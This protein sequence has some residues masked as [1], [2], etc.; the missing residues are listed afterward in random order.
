MFKITNQFSKKIIAFT[1]SA[2]LIV[3]AS[4]F[5]GQIAR[6]ATAPDL[7]VS[8]GAEIGLPT[9]DVRVVIMRIIRA[10]LGLLG[11]VAVGLILYAGFLWMTAGG[12][13]D[14][15]GTAKKILINS[16]IGLAIILSSY[17]I[18][19]FIMN[20]LV[21][22]TTG[23]SQNQQCIGAECDGGSG[24]LPGG[25]SSFYISA[26]PISGP[27]CIRNVHPVI[28]FSR[29]VDINSVNRESN[30]TLVK[31]NAERVN[32][33]WNYV[34]GKFNVIQFDA[35]SS[36]APDEGNDCLE[37]N[38]TYILNINYSNITARGNS[39]VS[40]IGCRNSQTGVINTENCNG[41]N[42]KTGD[43]V[44]RKAPYIS[45]VAPAAGSSSQI[46]FPVMIRV[47]FDDDNGVQSINLFRDGI[48]ADSKTLTGC[49]KSGTL[50]L[51]WPTAGM[52]AGAYDLE[53]V[54]LDWA[55]GQGKD[56]RRLV[57]LPEHCFDS[58]QNEGETDIDCGGECRACPGSACVQNSE[59][60]SGFCDKGK[61][62]N[63][64]YISDYAPKSGA[65]GTMVAVVG[66]FFGE[67]KG[68]GGVYFSKV[69]NPQRDVEAD[70]IEAPVVD[71]NLGVDNWTNNQVVVR[72][73]VG[74]VSGPIKI[75]R[76]DKIYSDL[77]NDDVGM[78]LLDFQVNNIVRPGICA[79]NPSSALPESD[80]IISGENFGD[81]Q[82]NPNV[83]KTVFGL[84]KAAVKNWSGTSIRAVV[85][86]SDVATVGVSVFN[87]DIESN[88]YRFTVL[89]G[90]SETSPVVSTIS[91]NSGPGGTY[92]TIFGKNF[93]SNPGRVH[94]HESASEASAVISGDFSFPDDC[95]QAVW[96][97]DKVIVKFPKG[98]GTLNTN[99]FVQV[100]TA[101]NKSSEFNNSWRFKL[102]E[103]VL[104]P[105][106]CKITP[107]AG[108]VPFPQ[109]YSPMEIIGENFGNTKD[110][111]DVYFWRAG[112]RNDSIN[113]RVKVDKGNSFVL[114][115]INNGQKI[116]LFPPAGTETGDVVAV[117]SNIL[118][119]P[120]RFEVSDCT[121][122]TPGKPAN[123]CVEAGTKCCVVGSDKGLCRPVGELCAGET[124][125]AGYIWR[126]STGKIP[127]VPHVV[128]RCDG[129]NNI[130]T[131]SPRKEDGSA[132]RDTCRT[133]LAVIEF[134][135]Q[136]DPKTVTK[137]LDN[138]IVNSC[139]DIN[140]GQCVNPIK[141]DLANSS[142][143]LKAAVN[144]LGQ[145]PRDYL[146]LQP[147]AGRWA[148]NAWYQVVLKTGIKSLAKTGEPALSLAQD[149]AC[150]VKDSAYCYV[151][152]TGVE[153]CHL[154]KVII[155]P[156]SYLTE[157]LG[158]PM[159]DKND[160]VVNYYGN[161]LSKQ[162]CVMMNMDG[163]IWDWSV[164]EADRLYTDIFQTRGL[165][166]N[167]SALSNTVAVGLNRPPIDAVNISVT[168][169]KDGEPVKVGYSP[170]TIDLSA[171]Q[172]VDAWPKCLE[173]CTNVEVG[174]KFSTTMSASQRY[175]DGLI[176]PMGKE[177]V[178]LYTC[179][180]EN[181]LSVSANPV[182]IGALL[183]QDKQTITIQYG[184]SLSP[185]TIYKA[186]V[187]AP[188]STPA[189]P[190]LGSA[191]RLNDVAIFGKPMDQ[192][193][194]WV[195]RTKKDSCLI[196]RVEVAPSVFMARDVHD[197]AIFSAQPYSSPD[198]CNA[199]GQK[200]NPWSVGWNW[201]S[202]VES[203]ATVSTSA[204]KGKNKYCT[205]SCVRKG[206]DIPST[207]KVGFPICGNGMVEAG[208]DCDT[209]NK[210]KN[211][212]LNCLYLGN[213]TTCGNGNIDRE[214]NYAVTGYGEE[215]D[216]TV[217]ATAIG[218]DNT[219][220][221]T[222]SKISATP[223]VG[224]SVC[225]NST[226]G[227]GED[228]DLGIAGDLAQPVSA[229]GCSSNCLHTGS[230][231]S[232]AWCNNQKVA[233]TYGGFTL[234]E[235]SK[236]CAVSYSQ[237]GNKVA[238]PDEDSSCDTAAGV[239][240]NCNEFC[241]LKIGDS[242]EDVFN[243]SCANPNNDILSGCN[244][245]F[246][247]KGSSLYYDV[248]SVCGD[249]KVGI[250]EDAGCESQ[251]YF[252]EVNSYYKEGLFDPWVLVIGQGRGAS[253]PNTNPPEQKTDIIG[254]TSQD[255][256]GGVEK[257]GRGEYKI[258]CGFTTDDECKQA[259]GVDY[260]VGADS[261][262]YLYPKVLSTVPATANPIKTNVCPN[263]AIEIN[264]SGVIDPNT[265]SG[266]LVIAQGVDVESCGSLQDVTSLLAINDQQNN[267]W[268]E[269]LASKV[270]K[271][272]KDVFSPDA[273]AANGQ[274]R[275]WCAGKDLGTPTVIVGSD[276][277]TSKVSV[278]LSAPLTLNTQ[279]AVILKPGIKDIRGVSVGVDVKQIRRHLFRYGKNINWQFRTGIKVCAI[280]SVEVNPSQHYFSRAYTGT[281]LEAVAKT[282]SG[283]SIQ[284]IQ[285]SYD[286]NYV[287]GPMQNVYVNLSATN[288]NINFVTSTNVNG[289]I[290]IRASANVIEN[291][292]VG[293][294]GSVGLAATG[295]AH[296]IV[297][298]CENP[299]P[300]KDLFLSDINGGKTGPFNILP[301]EDRVNNN[302]G[303]D[304]L[305]DQFNNTA[306]AKAD[307]GGY[308]NF[309][310]YYCADSG[311]T[312]KND[313][314]P[315][316]R[317]AVQGKADQLGSSNVGAVLLKRF[318]LT[319]NKNSDAIGIQILRN[320]RH[321][322]VK[323]WYENDAAAGGA[324]FVGQKQ[325]I[326]IDGYDAYADS[327]NIYV[328]AL[329]ITN[330]PQANSL[331][332]VYNNIY[333]FSINNDASK[334]TRTVF[335]QVVKNLRFNVN[336]TNYGFCGINE[337]NPNF[338]TQ[339]Q[340]DL[341]CPIG[342][343]CSAQID[344]LKRNY[345]RLR[346]LNYIQNELDN[347]ANKNNGAYPA[348]TEG[349][350]L[351]G[352]AVSTWNMG[353]AALGT[354][355]GKSLPVDP[356][357]VLGKAGTCSAAKNKACTVDGQCPQG[358]TC[359]L[360]DA[361]TG[362][363]DADRRYSFACN[364]NSLAF[365]YSHTPEN[366]GYIL[367]T[368]LEK[369]FG[370][371]NNLAIGN[372]NNFLAAFL[373]NTNKVQVIGENNN[374]I[375]T[376]ADE[377]SSEQAGGCGDG[378]INSANE[379]CDPKGAKEY[380]PTCVNGKVAVKICSEQCKWIEAPSEDCAGVL[381][382][383]GNG[384]K[385]VGE[386]CDEGK[387]LNGKYGH[388]S[389]DCNSLGEACG[390]GRVN[391]PNEL[392]DWD[393][394]RLNRSLFSVYAPPNYIGTCAN[395]GSVCYS[396]NDCPTDKGCSNNANKRCNTV[397]DCDTNFCI[398]NPGR[399]CSSG[400]YTQTKVLVG[401]KMKVVITNP[402]K[403][404]NVVG[405]NATCATCA[406]FGMTGNDLA[407]CYLSYTD[408]TCKLSGEKYVCNLVG[409]GSKFGE[410]NLGATPNCVKGYKQ[411]YNCTVTNKGQND[412]CTYD[413]KASFSL[414]KAPTNTNCAVDNSITCQ[415]SF[416]SCNKLPSPF[417]ISRKNG[418]DLKIID[419]ENKVRYARQAENSCNWDCKTRGPYCGDGVIQERYGEECDGNEI[420]TVGG[421]TGQRVCSNTCNM[422]TPAA[423]NWRFDS[424][425][426]GQDSSDNKLNALDCTGHCPIM[427]NNG[428]FGTAGNFT[429]TNYLEVSH[430]NKLM[431]DKFTIEAWINPQE[432]NQSNSVIIQKSGGTTGGYALYL[433]K[434]QIKF[435]I[436][437][438]TKYANSVETAISGNV[439]GVNNWIH[440]LGVYD[441]NN[442]KLYVNSQQVAMTNNISVGK[443]DLNLMI[444]AGSGGTNG[445]RGKIDE[446]SYYDRVLTPAEISDRYQNAKG[447]FCSTAPATAVKPDSATARCGN[448]VVD[449]SL[450]EQCDL[451]DGNNGV[452][453]TPAYNRTCTYCSNDC[454]TI[455]RDPISFCG[456]G[457]I[458]TI[459]AATGA[460]EACDFTTING[461]LNVWSLTKSGAT[462]VD[463]DDV[464]KGY[465][466]KTCSSDSNPNTYYKGERS[467]ASDCTAFL[468]DCVICGFDDKN[469]VKIVGNL[470]DVL[471]A[472]GGYRGEY[473]NIP[474]DYGT[475][476]IKLFINNSF[477]A[478]EF[479]GGQEGA[480]KQYS[481]EKVSANPA[482]SNS[483]PAYRLHL[484]DNDNGHN[485]EHSLAVSLDPNPWQYDLILSPTIF[486]SNHFQNRPNDIRVV[487]SWTGAGNEA[488][489]VSG[490]FVPS[491]AAV[492][493]Y[494]NAYFC[495][496]P[497]G[498]SS[499]L[500]DGHGKKIGVW[501][502]QYP[503]NDN[504]F[505]HLI[506]YT[507]DTSNKNNAN[508]Y[509]GVDTNFD[510]LPANGTSQWPY[511]ATGTYPFYIKS[512]AGPIQN[513]NTNL[514]VSVYLP[515]V[516]SDS[517]SGYYDKPDQVFDFN[518]VKTSDYEGAEYW[519][520]FNIRR[521]DF[522][523]VGAV[524][525]RI[526]KVKELNIDDNSITVLSDGKIVTDPRDFNYR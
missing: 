216:P 37:A 439:A 3:V 409:V 485:V 385:E 422:V 52:K 376:Q 141:V 367:R 506:T 230:Q 362:W 516:Y 402:K 513:A 144:Q 521:A 324:G 284:P 420:C 375:C 171:P 82:I 240:D 34:N 149:R 295:R 56:D 212:S 334:E 66:R 8:Y 431:T 377:I 359:V 400:C 308:F 193:Y 45:F 115:N 391:E 31:Q 408:G 51:S 501:Y 451:G 383:C 510:C 83:Y 220:R 76:G 219:C 81:A 438:A 331:G 113:G 42:I 289:E 499:K 256:A 372:W 347:Y 285:G 456:D 405:V 28:T 380:D 491:I 416:A 412:I 180:D 69:A 410:I 163:Y 384:K 87:N 415:S 17:S 222:G 223:Q 472:D 270:K 432:I 160:Q 445:F 203:V 21:E 444:G 425:K 107:A 455:S 207:T 482:C 365:R 133:S 325:S 61:C 118:S 443:S 57:L 46:G 474:G 145:D 18:V 257:N 395:T 503:A 298:L 136:I 465:K 241:L 176:S 164:A 44:D 229:L 233:G 469:G 251:Q 386:V 105:G 55:A 413:Y 477:V 450:N 327:N 424:N 226:I 224:L 361:A 78:S 354:A 248:P 211:C 468:P 263:T 392:C 167:V 291:K 186:V 208:E 366:S 243:N 60:A 494:D 290:D 199:N 338:D 33:T 185:N 271:I 463:F 116:N 85:P 371:D 91:P 345:S 19:S 407:N 104:K 250:G 459:N 497:S 505:T 484:T 381:T 54:A 138:V 108:P 316:F 135:K 350:F 26:L 417:F 511:M 332:N 132:R 162:T 84:N 209:P 151:F 237:C 234:E 286:W 399:L 495:G 281:I 225:N 4:L 517:A 210:E 32:G 323:E 358:E 320:D 487:V 294:G 169:N 312:G 504:L 194:S 351:P 464:R 449:P 188:S 53:A 277:T 99:Y 305:S 303:Y 6:A 156:Y 15:V 38:T 183:S 336:L 29:E 249:A 153:D 98:L 140:N 119:N 337:A 72:V 59:C 88:S 14:Q 122:A 24:G 13:E 315:Y 525:N 246:N 269:F 260:S 73:P 80:V 507:I 112:A 411:S 129:G 296:L 317:V 282:E 103:G 382:T 481:V 49:Q 498:Y 242:P 262:C 67:D 9:T 218:C 292:S 486:S 155:T 446:V 441:G 293:A 318:I 86:F 520:V 300:P 339:C 11:I 68:Q 184:A 206:S 16:V 272:F 265:L 475:K 275:K 227:S 48:L 7:G 426:I 97:N 187:S 166:A 205:S 158:E 423:A 47:K 341:D 221:R 524:E 526:S 346:S 493:M 388:C 418:E 370:S 94:F 344:K 71:C 161:G 440:V 179:A 401:A 189:I 480:K 421:V 419:I 168:A 5:V 22:A 204:S 143:S 306:M 200:L 139:S 102:V 254:S 255:T 142:F 202:S 355:V 273:L 114:S 101:D 430:N 192:E 434:T 65:I 299:W 373:K 508:S 109:G 352:Q 172:V 280:S 268:Y 39:S 261:C 195:F 131:P 466:V 313:D 502:H 454:R 523:G 297:F 488:S 349:T 274:P 117:V 12:N 357:D 92:I 110:N 453:C 266:N 130:P 512:V 30:I 43:G 177:A 458:D 121:I 258:A 335:E 442:G 70:W 174:V 253:D 462:E 393:E 353:W 126:F 396:D 175:A 288:S 461:L 111:L 433:D 120:I 64:M 50:D 374:G 127:A 406:D 173:A 178:R 302:D 191:A 23:Q 476:N 154:D 379:E 181:C 515:K 159:K 490:F 368:K 514:K 478:G 460:K 90:I 278:K 235:F 75:V 378:I 63:R 245:A 252:T 360:H 500:E 522:P 457:V 369:I 244:E 314:L 231:L 182:N 470:L 447:W 321:L 436:Y 123:S 150:E 106:I 124:L 301:F 214:Q 40:L 333:L 170:L 319:N 414:N 342:Q 279:Y 128:D 329:N 435:S 95:A 309:S 79:I 496:N 363:S 330:P 467:C 287:W 364:T 387:D 20:K 356:V 215:C 238:D 479:V 2:I 343:T 404:D 448:G 307:T 10:A 509:V 283:E 201:K 217:P 492:S 311:S 483:D 340:T 196:N 35:N 134:D 236:A 1:L 427:V 519:H 62:V 389:M 25:M 390:N 228:C 148:E 276:Q 36:C 146:A 428:K 322:T 437:R 198:A 518:R 328:D 489:F 152:K 403:R 397:S 247:H 100:M 304:L 96:T 473:V 93:G 89:G 348:L 58:T 137:I 429:G 147:A 394:G 452:P 239:S 398:D 157:I 259:R 190:Q 267:S 27:V 77:S 326:K 165:M 310:T 125:S 74:A 197:R 471:N 213:D 264:F 232:S 41:I